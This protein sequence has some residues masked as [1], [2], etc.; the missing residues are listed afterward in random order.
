M[1]VNLPTFTQPRR[2][3]VKV[4]ALVPIFEAYLINGRLL[5]SREIYG[6][7]DLMASSSDEGSYENRK[8]D[9]GVMM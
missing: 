2:F 7:C 1:K 4:R 3:E 5:R 8:C 6:R 9:I